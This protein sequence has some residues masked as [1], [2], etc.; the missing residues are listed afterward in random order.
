MR[1]SNLRK[2]IS[3]RVV[4]GLAAIM[5]VGTLGAASITAFANN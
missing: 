5:A 3:N 4:C 1:K 2:R